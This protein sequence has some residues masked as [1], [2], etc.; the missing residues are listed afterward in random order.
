MALHRAEQAVWHMALPTR[1]LVEEL[2]AADDPLGI[3]QHPVR[4]LA[5]IEGPFEI[6]DFGIPPE[7]AGSG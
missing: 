3:A 6:V 4:M 7:E 1:W 2:A 5:S